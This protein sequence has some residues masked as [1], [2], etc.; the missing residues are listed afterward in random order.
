MFFPNVDL[1]LASQ[2][3]MLTISTLLFGL[4]GLRQNIQN[5]FS[6][7]NSEK[8]SKSDTSNEKGDFIQSKINKIRQE[9][10]E[11]LTK[12][13]KTFRACIYLG[14]ISIVL[15]AMNYYWFKTTSLDNVFFI[16]F[17]IQLYGLGVNVHR[18]K[19]FYELDIEEEYRKLDKQWENISFV[20][21]KLRK[22]ETFPVDNLIKEKRDGL[23]KCL[24]NN[25]KSFR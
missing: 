11:S 2:L 12:M 15:L 14:I 6:N 17:A 23:L 22:G 25:I 16:F 21:S 20:V 9:T 18:F 13:G 7:N 3:V 5:Q 10:L 24:W 4:A 19:K 8:G 1:P